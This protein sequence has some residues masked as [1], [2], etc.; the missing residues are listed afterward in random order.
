MVLNE[1]A[2]GLRSMSWGVG[3]FE[4]LSGEE[5]AAVLR[6]IADFCLQARATSEDGAESIER[7][8]LRSTFTPGVLIV[9]GRIT[10]QLAKIVGLPQ[11][12]RVKSFR[13]LI[14]LLGVADGRRR[15][16]YCSAGCSHDWHHLSLN[17]E[18]GETDG[19]FELP[20]EGCGRMPR[21]G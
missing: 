15:E 3:W 4:G 9:R 7:A 8:G 1:L 19:S 14:A 11:D 10:E 6:E 2:Q 5:Q 16:R 17:G 12:E 18:T 13:L 20:S 21:H